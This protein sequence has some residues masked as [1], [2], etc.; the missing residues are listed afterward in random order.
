MRE[1]ERETKQHNPLSCILH[2]KFKS[3]MHNEFYSTR[4]SLYLHH[5]HYFCS[6]QLIQGKNRVES[7]KQTVQIR[8][9]L[10]N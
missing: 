4:D 2:Q 5:L 9:V 1:K 8:L 6:V 3:N 7:T 10:F